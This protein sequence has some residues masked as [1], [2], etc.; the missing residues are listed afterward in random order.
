MLQANLGPSFAQ[1]T[2]SMATGG[3]VTT[4]KTKKNKNI[5]PNVKII[6]DES[7]G[8]HDENIA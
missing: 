8:L 5:K 4:S 3:G 1:C 2:P 6:L 7:Y